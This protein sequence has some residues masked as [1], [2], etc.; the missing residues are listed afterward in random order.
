MGRE[1]MGHG[2]RYSSEVFDSMKCY[3]QSGCRQRV[4]GDTVVVRV[5]YCSF[6]VNARVFSRFSDAMKL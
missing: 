6:D 2:S 3:H 4:L 5:A 1:I